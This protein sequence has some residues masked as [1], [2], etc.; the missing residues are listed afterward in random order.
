MNLFIEDADIWFKRNKFPRVEDEGKIRISIG[1]SGVDLKI[2]LRTFIRAKDIIEVDRVIC[3]V[4]NMKLHLY[5]TRHKCA[6][7]PPLVPS[8]CPCKLS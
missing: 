3:D 2:I 7:P 5:E 1:G 6:P 8:I 4:H